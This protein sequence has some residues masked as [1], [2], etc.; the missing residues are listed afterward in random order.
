MNR[1]STSRFTPQQLAD[2]LTESSQKFALLRQSANAAVNQEFGNDLVYKSA[3]L[4]ASSGGYKEQQVLLAP[5]ETSHMLQHLVFETANASQA[6]FFNRLL[7]DYGND[8]MQT[9]EQ[10]G[11]LLNRD[12]K[13][14]GNSLQQK[15]K[16]GDRIL[17]RA[18]VQEWAEWNSLQRTKATFSEINSQFKSGGAEKATWA[19]DEQLNAKNFQDYYHNVRGEDHM[20]DVM[21]MLTKIAE[22]KKK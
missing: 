2:M 12:P 13:E 1:D 22:K 9:L 18:L 14:L 4:G 20:N 3:Q 21:A 17:K 16:D 5:N 19:F 7:S 10:Y 6:S 8:K 11:K 15:Y